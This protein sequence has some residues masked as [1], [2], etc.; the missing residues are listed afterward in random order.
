[1]NLAHLDKLI[2]EKPGVVVGLWDATEEHSRQ[3]EFFTKVMENSALGNQNENLFYCFV[4]CTSIPE[5]I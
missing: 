1:M 4:N 3:N 2:N 5:A